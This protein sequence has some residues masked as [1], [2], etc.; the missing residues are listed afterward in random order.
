MKLSE[1][2]NPLEQRR[3]A[4][5]ILDS[6]LTKEQVF[7]VL[8]SAAELDKQGIKPDAFFK[9]VNVVYDQFIEPKN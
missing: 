9:A 6:S 1:M 7:S 4:K 2:F 5:I 3:I 8:E